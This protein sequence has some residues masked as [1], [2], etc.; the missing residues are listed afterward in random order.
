MKSLF[1]AGLLGR[2]MATK[3]T[4]PGEDVVVLNQ[5]QPQQPASQKYDPFAGMNTAPGNKTL[6]PTQKPTV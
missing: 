3:T 4:N 6:I 1:K 5:K 2:L